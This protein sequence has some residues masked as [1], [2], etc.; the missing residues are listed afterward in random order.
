MEDLDE[1]T[2][3]PVLR[4]GLGEVARSWKGEERGAVA[5]IQP[6]EFALYSGRIGGATA[7]AVDGT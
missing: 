1:R 2:S 7:L 4:S 6:E 5:E 3:N